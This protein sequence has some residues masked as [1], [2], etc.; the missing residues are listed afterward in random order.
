LRRRCRRGGGGGGEQLAVD[1]AG[2]PLK[3]ALRAL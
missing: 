2:E 3:K 1:G